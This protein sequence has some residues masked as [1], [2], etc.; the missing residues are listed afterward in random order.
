[1][2]TDYD[3][4]WNTDGFNELQSISDNHI[5]NM[6]PRDLSITAAELAKEYTEVVENIHCRHD[7]GMND[8]ENKQ[9]ICVDIIHDIDEKL[10]QEVDALG[11]SLLNVM[12]SV[13]EE[14]WDMFSKICV[15]DSD[16]IYTLEFGMPAVMW[17]LAVQYD[18]T[19]LQK[20]IR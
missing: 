4:Q 3:D 12:T 20:I 16:V 6:V 7:S 11:T 10:Q 14:N 1:M 15:Y 5:R 19:L 18:L 9:N 13:D 2:S 17:P 8:A